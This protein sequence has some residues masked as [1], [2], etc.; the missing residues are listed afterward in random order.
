MKEWLILV[1]EQAIVLI[2]AIALIVILFGTI[3]AFLTAFGVTFRRPS[4]TER[5]HVW[6]RFGRWLVAGLTFQLA[7]DILETSISTSWDAIGR[8]AAVAV[9]RTFLN[10]FLER[11]LA[12]VRAEP[13]ATAPSRA[14]R[15]AVLVL[16]LGAGLAQ[17]GCAS[18]TAASLTPREQ[19]AYDVFAQCWAAGGPPTPR[20]SAIEEPDGRVVG[21]IY[22]YVEQRRAVAAC[23]KARGFVGEPDRQ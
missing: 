1:S 4:E 20:F 16:G 15:A 23:M 3:E 17:P 5:R 22:G 8:L 6:L 12:E 13:E 18:P 11:D 19:I 2:D 14:T 21:T 9:V 10:Y 7:A